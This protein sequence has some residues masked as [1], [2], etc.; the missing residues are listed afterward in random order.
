[1][2]IIYYILYFRC[3]FVKCGVGWW[4]KIRVSVVVCFCCC[5]AFP[6]NRSDENSNDEMKCFVIVLFS[7][8]LF[9]WMMV[10]LI[11]P[12]SSLSYIFRLSFSLRCYYC[13]GWLSSFIIYLC[14]CVIQLVSLSGVCVCRSITKIICQCRTN[15]K[16]PSFRLCLT[17]HE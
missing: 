2:R 17:L 7:L 14:V 3:V 5:F 6:P 13:C 4:R 9:G 1:M 8:L 16:A 11:W 15:K 12:I 10:D